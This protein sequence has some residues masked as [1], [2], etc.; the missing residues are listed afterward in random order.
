MSPLRRVHRRLFVSNDRT[1]DQLL[2]VLVYAPVGL[3]YEAKELIPKLA[4]RGRGQVALLRF[5]QRV[6]A[7]QGTAETA[8]RVRATL[9]DTIDTVG[10]WFASGSDGRVSDD[11]VADSQQGVADA[12]ATDGTDLGVAETVQTQ[13]SHDAVADSQ[14]GVADAEATDGT[15]LGVAETAETQASHDAVADSEQGVADAEATDG[16][17]LGVAETVQTQASEEAAP[18]GAGRDEPGEPFASY[19][20]MT[21]RE[22]ITLL[23]QLGPTALDAVLRYE[24]NNRARSTVLNR[25]AQL[26]NS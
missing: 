17:D 22:I 13:A 15:D 8:E 4:E 3:A 14:Q 26:R 18:F 24:K 1:I 7:Q 10:T 12:E 6:A 23:A 20:S 25:V 16:T 5:A 2:D 11:G 21:A 9:L 19:D